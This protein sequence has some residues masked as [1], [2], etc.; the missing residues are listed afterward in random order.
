MS[1]EYNLKGS[2]VEA[3]SRGNAGCSLRI[4]IS[5]LACNLK[6]SGLPRV[7]EFSEDVTGNRLKTSVLEVVRRSTPKPQHT[8]GIQAVVGRR[9]ALTCHRGQFENLNSD[10]DPTRAHLPLSCTPLGLYTRFGACSTSC[11][12]KTRVGGWMAQATR[13]HA[14]LAEIK[15]VC[16]GTLAL[17]ERHIIDLCVFV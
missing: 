3:K 1:W 14:V 11:I 16:N 9:C 2:R 5:D 13:G 15:L 8:R 4:T 12:A 17:G 6:E 10:H 7:R